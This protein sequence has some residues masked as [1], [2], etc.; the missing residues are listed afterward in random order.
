MYTYSTCV[1]IILLYRLKL[2]APPDRVTSLRD[3]Y[4]TASPNH[5]TC[6]RISRVYRDTLWFTSAVLVRF[7]DSWQTCALCLSQL[8]AQ[9]PPPL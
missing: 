9:P 5:D 7:N 1:R 4:K 8:F 2:V 3:R 6:T